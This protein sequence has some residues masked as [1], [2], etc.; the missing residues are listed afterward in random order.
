MLIPCSRARAVFGA[1]GVRLD[2][3]T[4][5][6]MVWDEH[7]GTYVLRVDDLETSETAPGEPDT[8]IVLSIPLS[9]GTGFRRDLEEFAAQQQL[10]LAPPPPPELAEPVILAACHLPVRN[11]FI[12]AEDPH[13]TVRRQG[14]T[15]EIAVAGNFKSRR[16]PCQAAD[17]VIHLDR[18]AMAR[19][20]ALTL[21][22]A[23]EEG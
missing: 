12:F 18:A 5:G 8:G 9:P 2:R 4:P 15:L 16:V 22:L 11:L 1:L 20:A 6:S 7:G 23:R 19:L 17:L 10:P 14:E 13:L 21:S 3:A